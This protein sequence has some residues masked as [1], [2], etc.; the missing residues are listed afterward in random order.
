MH[1]L[2][3][4]IFYIILF[5][6]SISN[7]QEHDIKEGK[8]YLKGQASIE[9]YNTKIKADY[10]E[11]NWKNGDLYAQ[12]KKKSVFLQ[13]DNHQYTF[14]KIHMNLNDQIGEAKN[15]YIK[16]KN[17]II[18]AHDFLKKKE[19]ILMKK[20]I[21]ISDPFFLKDRDSSP[22]F[23][24]KTD[25]LKYSYSKKYIFSG[26]IFFYWYRVP[27][28]IF[29]PFFYMPIKFNQSPSPYGFKYP[30][31]GI[32]NK[33]IYM[34]D[35]GLFFP[36]SDLLNFRM[37]ASIY[38]TEK[39]KI[40]TRIEYKLKYSYHGFIDFDYQNTP[41]QKKN[42]LF[43]WK[44][45]SDRKSNNEMSF[46]AN[47]NYDNA[48]LYKKNENFSYINIRKKLSDYLWFMDIY[49]IQNP[50]KKKVNFI[51]PELI[52]YTKSI[53]FDDKKNL[54]L[55]HVNIENRLFFKNSIE[56]HN[57]TYFHA[58][59]NHYMMMNAYSSFFYPYLKI[60]SQIFYKDLYT[61]DLPYFHVS[62][63]QK[64]DISTNIISVPFYKIWKL[65]KSILLKHEIEPILS[66]HMIYY[67]PV[68]YNVKNHFEKRINLI[69]NNNWIIKNTWP[70]VN[71]YKKIEIFK[72]M[73]FS[74]ILDNNFIKWKNFYLMGDV[75]LTKNLA[76]KYKAGINWEWEEEKKKNQNN[77]L[78]DFSFFSN[79]NIHFSPVKNEFNKKGKNRYDYFFFDQKNYAKYTIP[80]S[81]EIDFRSIY[82]NY[83]NKKKWF[84][85]LLSINGSINITKY[86]KVSFHTDYDFLKKKI[87]FA[88]IIFNRDLRSFEMS[89]NWNFEKSS[90]WSFFI[91]LKDPNFK[92]IIQ[93]NERKIN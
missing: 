77:I 5:L 85:N 62:N 30:K 74:F 23:Y 92:N 51:I 27:M 7:I 4:Y 59:F 44:H 86:W 18:I 31:F 20:V 42:Y 50:S 39:W 87:I 93:Y 80:L 67:P 52:L 54:F 66:F 78:F 24:L 68:F 25:Y 13:K 1:Q 8:S 57:T 21:Y 65:K 48:F 2:R 49:M 9:Y 91:G 70:H 11:F 19:D 45:N 36:I 17:Y 73:N 69:L 84:Q 26:P 53:L 3:F 32:Q 75:D 29:L 43:Q 14:S 16:E 10:I 79:Y 38:G 40:K 55:S 37:N 33:K 34:E 46:N 76:A 35:I 60:S 89:F 72:E 6:F 81:L 28:P 12:S 56:S 88:N 64:M 61:W 41:T 15:F 47:V 71:I 22:D 90:D 82:E 63:Y 58:G 83:F